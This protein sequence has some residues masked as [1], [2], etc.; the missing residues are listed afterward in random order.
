MSFVHCFAIP[1]PRALWAETLGAAHD[2]LT[3]SQTAT[4]PA[5]EEI[6]NTAD[7]SSVGKTVI[8]RIVPVRTKVPRD[9]SADAQTGTENEEPK[10]A[11]AKVLF[12]GPIRTGTSVIPT[13]CAKDNVRYGPPVVAHSVLAPDEAALEPNFAPSVAQPDGEAEVAEATSAAVRTMGPTPS[14]KTMAPS[15]CAEEHG[16]HTSVVAQ[17]VPAP[18]AVEEA[19]PELAVDS[20][21]VHIFALVTAAEDIDTP[22]D[23][24]AIQL[25]VTTPAE[26]SETPV[27]QN[28]PMVLSSWRVGSTTRCCWLRAE[29]GTAIL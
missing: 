25:A 12:T 22:M 18:V 26:V 11:S 16:L 19:A 9:V 20:S 6:G 3:S 8:P 21:V 10:C 1:D 23:A 15:S 17:S 4:I 24:S 28:L 29:F 2:D 13:P 7:A 27:V 5:A 14:E